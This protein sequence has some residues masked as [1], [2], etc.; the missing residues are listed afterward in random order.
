MTTTPTRRLRD[1]ERGLSPFMLI[2]AVMAFSIVS[3]GLVAGL[4]A[5][6]Q[7]SATMQV[8]AQLTDA[9][10]A[11]AREPV[12]QG[13]AATQALPASGPLQFE[14]G[15][16][17]ATATRTVEVDAAT[18]AARVTVTVGKFNGSEFADTSTC[19]ATPTGCIVISEMVSGAAS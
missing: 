19:D 6:M 5:S 14:V 2:A 16:F 4:I 8:N 11:A 15:A 10:S 3:V 1:D 17:T 7:A 12:R 13:F 18:S 9:A